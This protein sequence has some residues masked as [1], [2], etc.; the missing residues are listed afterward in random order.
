MDTK[1]I[2]VVAAEIYPV[3]SDEQDFWQAGDS[4]RKQIYFR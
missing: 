2:Q 4:T 3:P 1:Q